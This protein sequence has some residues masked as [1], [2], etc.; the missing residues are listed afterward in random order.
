MGDGADYLFER[1]EYEAE[2]ALREQREKE[3]YNTTAMLEKMSDTELLDYLCKQ[4]KKLD[5]LD[6]FKTYTTAKRIKDNGW[7]PTKKQREALINTA[8]IALN[9]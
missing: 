4:G 9:T 7:T 1:D 6:T 2:C 3:I 5:T 8:A